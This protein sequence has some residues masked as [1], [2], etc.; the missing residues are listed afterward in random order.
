MAWRYRDRVTKAFVGVSTYNRSKSRGGTKFERVSDKHW[1]SSGSLTRKT[2]SASA[3]KH[4]T[5]KRDASE[6]K[7]EQ[8]SKPSEA[9]KTFREYQ[10]QMKK[11]AKRRSADYY[12][13][14]DT[15]PEYETGVD[16]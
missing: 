5:K 1:K 2:S 8:K 14:Y 7:A 11:K 15:G 12:D 3:P 10:E 4:S 9:P 13:D 16:Y 6:G